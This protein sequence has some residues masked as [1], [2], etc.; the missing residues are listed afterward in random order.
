[1]ER[2]A[3]LQANQEQQQSKVASS[4]R[5]LVAGTGGNVELGSKMYSV[6]IESSTR[7][8]S[9]SSTYIRLTHKPTKAA[10]VVLP[11]A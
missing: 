5:D 3:L 7:R 11:S 10:L 8:V 9:A 4:E 6:T 2:T 1:M